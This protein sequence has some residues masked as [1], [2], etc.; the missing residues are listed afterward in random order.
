MLHIFF[1]VYL[2]KYRQAVPDKLIEEIADSLKITPAEV[3]N[4]LSS[5]STDIQISDAAVRSKRYGGLERHSEPED[6]TK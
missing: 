4:Y 5:Y 2:S 3:T 1:D 6:K